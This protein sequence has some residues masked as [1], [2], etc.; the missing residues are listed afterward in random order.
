MKTVRSTDISKHTNNKV[1]IKQQQALILTK[2]STEPVYRTGSC[3]YL[4]VVTKVSVLQELHG[5]VVH[6]VT[7]LAPVFARV[8]ELIPGLHT[9]LHLER[10]L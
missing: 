6:R 9:A 7:E 10:Q 2:S 4:L 3:L 1:P 8:K 5:R